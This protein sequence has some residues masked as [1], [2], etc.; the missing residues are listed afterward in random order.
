MSQPHF[1]G[2]TAGS[3][4]GAGESSLSLQFKAEMSN[5]NVPLHPVVV[6]IVQPKS[7]YLMGSRDLGKRALFELRNQLYCFTNQLANFV[8]LF[9]FN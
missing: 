6:I 7:L 3:G 5:A 2:N 1:E 9:V 8:P 4:P